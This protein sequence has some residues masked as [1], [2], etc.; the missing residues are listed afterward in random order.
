[1][2]NGKC[3][4]HWPA[5]R[6]QRVRC[7]FLTVRC[8]RV[9]AGVALRRFRRPAIQLLTRAG[10]NLL[11]GPTPFP[12][13]PSDAGRGAHPGFSN[14]QAR[15]RSRRRRSLTSTTGFRTGWRASATPANGWKQPLSVTDTADKTGR[16]GFRFL[17]PPVSES[18]PLPSSAVAC[19]G[20]RRRLSRR[21][22]RRPSRRASSE[23]CCIRI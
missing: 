10:A 16:R 1:M 14:L 23:G 21:R 9:R 11:M 22:A 15:A 6:R 19:S 13:G 17:T 7:H 20:A 12:L 2:R 5:T 8:R 3:A 4:A 18:P